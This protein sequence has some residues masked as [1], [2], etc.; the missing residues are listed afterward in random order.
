MQFGTLLVGHQE[1]QLAT[2]QRLPCR[3]FADH[4]LTRINFTKA[5]KMV[6]YMLVFGSCFVYWY[7]FCLCHMY[8]HVIIIL[9]IMWQSYQWRV[10]DCWCTACHSRVSHVF[11]GRRI[12]SACSN[13]GDVSEL[14]SPE[15]ISQPQ[16]READCNLRYVEWCSHYSV[17][18][19][20]LTTIW[21]FNQQG[22]NTLT[23]L[24]FALFISV[25]FC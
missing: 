3:S 2:F 4:R 8:R 21:Q 18:C 20:V 13:E 25:E 10:I 11:I 9:G 6:M 15:D 17:V 12:N 1:G 22:E 24:L 16:T 19:V 7:E 5:V 23:V 14:Y